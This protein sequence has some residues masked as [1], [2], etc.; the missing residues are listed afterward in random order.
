MNE[1]RRW[2]SGL[3]LALGLGLGQAGGV[4]ATPLLSFELPL[5]SEALGSPGLNVVEADQLSP[6]VQSLFEGGSDSLVARVVGSAEGTRTTDGALTWA[7]HGHRDPGNGKWNL[8]SF[9]YQHGATSPEDAD[10][11]Q[12]KRLEG[13]TQMLHQLAVQRGLTLSMNEVLNGIDLANQAPLAALDRGYI[14][15]LKE[16][17][18]LE[19]G[20]AEGI[21]F[22]RTW[23]YW[24][25]DLEAWNAPGLGN[26]WLS[27]SE[28]QRRRQEAIE[29][30]LERLR[31]KDR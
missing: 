14:D 22:A 20:E 27:I 24:D 4:G 30:V 29:G 5:R 13:Q 17:R 21:L 25:P 28:D 3:G 16:A 8:G 18:Q 10:Q 1:V 2:G 23:S 12:L 9:S 26:R 19:L 11:R 31:G 7:Y 15:W 6:R